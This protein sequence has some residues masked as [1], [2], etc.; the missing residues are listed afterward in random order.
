MDQQRQAA[1]SVKDQIRAR[2]IRDHRSVPLSLHISCFL[3][4]VGPGHTPDIHCREP[5]RSVFLSA[6][7]RARHALKS[8]THK[9]PLWSS[10]IPTICF[11]Q[12]VWRTSREIE[13]TAAQK[14][15]DQTDVPIQRVGP[16]ILRKNK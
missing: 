10:A 8:R 5:H 4:T 3:E 11:A 13:K 1:V 16:D 6:W 12:Y 15:Q 9:L 2:R 14:R 7:K